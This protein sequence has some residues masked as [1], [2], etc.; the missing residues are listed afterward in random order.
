MTEKIYGL[1]ASRGGDEWLKGAD[2]DPEALRLRYN[3]YQKDKRYADP[4]IQE[5]DSIVTFMGSTGGGLDFAPRCYVE[6]RVLDQF[7]K[8]E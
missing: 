3:A 8:K 5:G 1:Y 4:E 2:T 6:I 7:D